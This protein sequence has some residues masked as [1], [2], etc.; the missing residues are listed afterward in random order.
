MTQHLQG[1]LQDC[2]IIT[3]DASL[4]P[5]D[6]IEGLYVYWCS[7]RTEDA[8]PT[9]AVLDGLRL[10]GLETTR[11]SGAEYVEGLLLTGPVMKDFIVSCDFAGTW[12]RPE[13]AYS[14]DLDSVRDVAP[15]S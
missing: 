8:L 2:T 12:G 13:H 4:A 5:L 10:R 9:G 14:T 3:A 15:V 6:E 11:R 1:F 7:L